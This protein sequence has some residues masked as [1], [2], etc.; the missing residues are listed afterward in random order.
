MQQLSDD[1]L[2]RVIIALPFHDVI[3]LCSTDTAIRSFCLA[4]SKRRDIIWQHIIQTVFGSIPNYRTIVAKLSQKYYQTKRYENPRFNYLIYVNLIYQLD[5]GNQ[6]WIYHRQ[7][8]TD[9]LDRLIDQVGPETL[10]ENAAE[11]GRLE[12][13][14]YLVEQG[15]NIRAE[16]S[17]ALR[18]A[19]EN[20]YWSVVKYLLQLGTSIYV[21]DKYKILA[22]VAKDGDLDL[23]TYLV[24]N[25]LSSSTGQLVEDHQDEYS[26]ALR[27][28]SSNGQ[29]EVVKYLISA[30]VDIHTENDFILR[31]AAGWNH[32]AMV[33]YL[34]KLGS[35]VKAE[36]N[37]ALIQAA[38]NCHLDMIEYLISVGADIRARDDYALKVS[39]FH[40]CLDVVKYLV[41]QGANI[42]ANNDYAVRV[43]GEKGRVEMVKYLVEH[44]AK[45]YPT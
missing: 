13:V 1:I 7:N 10:L 40:G 42:H 31:Q 22:D 18:K 21:I 24:E 38:S 16:N 14:K 19:V 32:L 17:Y 6:A 44:G 28:A 11:Q 3:Q 29:W 27:S 15:V 9:S 20:K 43:A 25:H 30:G 34:I 12:V 8:D 41:E 39:A 5:P 33:K 37:D 26:H 2:T 4:N 35:D 36:N 45:I 23:V